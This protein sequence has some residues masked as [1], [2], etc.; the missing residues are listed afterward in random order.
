[1]I[2]NSWVNL[3]VAVASGLGIEW[4]S[5]LDR[6]NL[7]ENKALQNLVARSV[8]IRTPATAIVSDSSRIPTAL[9]DPVVV[10]PLGP[11]AFRDDDDVMHVV[12][13][14]LLPRS[15]ETLDALA[16]APFLIQQRL[17]AQEHL[18]IVTVRDQAWCCSLSAEGLPLDWR[19]ED[20]AHDGFRPADGYDDVLVQALR[21]ATE[22][23][24]GYSSQD[25]IVTKD[26]VW[27]IDL[28]PG[29]Q[30]LFLPDPVAD[31]VTRA[32]AT[33]LVGDV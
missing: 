14:N 7:A 12:H 18:R 3:L 9:G 28:N 30:W 31:D 23:G 6:L 2:R 19:R 11:G 15:S 16:G 29:G 8:G 20:E 21:I 4:L 10:K 13:A 26:A 17:V 33:W 25:W 27:F 5:P 1:M 32:I 24:V 22:L